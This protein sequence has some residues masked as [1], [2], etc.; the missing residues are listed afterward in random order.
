[1][2]SSN[3]AEQITGVFIV[4]YY[5]PWVHA[6]T[7]GVDLACIKIKKAGNTWTQAIDTY[8]IYVSKNRN[9]TEI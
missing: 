6:C 1:M 4:R 3:K 9:V 5:M 2:H 8:S 7:V